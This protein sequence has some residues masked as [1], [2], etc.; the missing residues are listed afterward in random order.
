MSLLRG[1]KKFFSL[2]FFTC[3]FFPRSSFFFVLNLFFFRWPRCSPYLPLF[4]LHSKKYGNCH[5]LDV[6]IWSTC[7]IHCTICHSKSKVH[8]SSFHWGSITTND[9]LILLNIEGKGFETIVH[10]IE[11]EFLIL[12]CPKQVQFLV[13]ICVCDKFQ[14]S[15]TYVVIGF[16][17]NIQQFIPKVIYPKSRKKFECWGV[18][19][20][21]HN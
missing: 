10:M 8:T 6:I 19:C 2:I 15:S 13:S 11:F 12:V 18:G 16:Q 7:D 17:E 20:S 21:F 4:H 1:K 14:L 5:V 3:F 9:G